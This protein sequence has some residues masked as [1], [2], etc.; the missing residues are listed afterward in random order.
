[1]WP[2][3]WA[4]V[5]P[6]AGLLFGGFSLGSF[7]FGGGVGVFLGEAFDATGGVDELL[8]AGEEGMAT[9]ADFDVKPVT[10][11]GGTGGEIVTAG[12]VYGDLVIVGVNT[13][14]HDAPVCRGRSARHPGKAREK[15]PRR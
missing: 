10:L 1:V 7:D 11:D 9:G 5:M 8:L 3:P 6:D 13:G 14:F 4:K 2:V 15:Q 12:A